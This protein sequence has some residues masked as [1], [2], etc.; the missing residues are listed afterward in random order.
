MRILKKQGIGI[1][2]AL[3]VMG[4]GA[5]S[6]SATT[7]EVAGTAKNQSVTFFATLASGATTIIADNAK[8]TLDTCSASEMQ[9]ST[10]GT[11]SA[12]SV[13][14]T[15]TALAFGSCT[16]LTSVLK[17]GTFSISWTSGTNGILS[18]GGTE[19]TVFWTTFGMWTICKTGAS[20]AL[21]TITGSGS[22]KATITVNT[23]LNCGVAGI[24]SWSGTYTVTT[25]EKLGVVN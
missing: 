24:A 3:A 13:S 18:S 4:V 23:N 8:T 25:P 14:G 11:F 10:E 1:A 9:A 19:V 17:R 21:G 22:G 6:A 5:A 12:A 15:V 16:H 20:T 2:V 7:L